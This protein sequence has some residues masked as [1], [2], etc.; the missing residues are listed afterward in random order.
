MPESNHLPLGWLKG[1]GPEALLVLS[2]RLRI[3]RNLEGYAFPHRASEVARKEIRGKVA[4]AG[5]QERSLKP[6]ELIELEKLSLLDRQVLVE[7]YLV[8]PHHIQDPSGRG[9]LEQPD[10]TVSIMI[11]EED[12]LRLQCF[13]SGLDLE[14][15]WSIL[16]AVD[17]AFESHLPYAFHEQ[18]GYL[19][20]CPTNLGTGLRASTLLHLPA[21]TFL[22]AMPSLIH[23]LNQLGIVVRGFYGEGTVS[24]GH[25]YQVSNALSL[26][27]T[28][29]DIV[30]R[31]SS[32]TRQVITQELQARDRLVKEQR[33][34]IEDRTWRAFAILKSAHIINSFEAM[35]HLSLTRLGVQ[36]GILP[37]VP[38][39]LLNEVILMT[40][41]ANLQKHFGVEPDPG[42]RDIAR[43]N[44]L[45][46]ALA[47]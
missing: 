23:S 40:R 33:P 18:W 15:G 28:E 35:E 4:E 2:S 43:A 36:L 29:E 42:K 25:F 8:S 38:V 41:P 3:A 39:G 12:H 32:V 19:V 11:N 34:L 14:K 1:D 44:Y 9:L 17:D 27:P 24:Q 20:A 7:D 10:G 31:V 6:M 46:N 37:P 16:N 30:S 45:R 5:K 13:L 21:L 22:Q 47:I 26:G